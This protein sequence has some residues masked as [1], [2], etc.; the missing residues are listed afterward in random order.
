MLLY[1]RQTQRP[2]RRIFILISAALLFFA[3]PLGAQAPEAGQSADDARSD[4][5]SLLLLDGIGPTSTV[6]DFDEALSFARSRE[7]RDIVEK[8]RKEWQ[9]EQTLKRNYLNLL[10]F[11]TFGMGAYCAAWNNNDIG[12]DF[13]VKMGG[14]HLPFNLVGSL[15]LSE[16]NA[17]LPKNA[18]KLYR[19]PVFN[20]G[21]A[22]RY[23]TGVKSLFVS[24]G[25]RYQWCLSNT[26]VNLDYMYHNKIE[27]PQNSHPALLV[28]A[29]QRIQHFEWSVGAVYDLSPA[30]QQQMMY[31]SPFYD[32]YGTRSVIDGRFRLM[33]S[34][35]FYF[36]A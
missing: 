2:V 33:L 17:I 23:N 6:A 28:N 26:Y 7:V 36:S 3:A 29:G 27:Q 14:D 10:G 5:T 4:R 21:V 22:M 18:S 9:K 8:R 30:Y 11:W 1:L 15:G 16:W 25:I 12:A 34:F 32:Y 31:E 24:S 13:I 35:V 20:I 19:W